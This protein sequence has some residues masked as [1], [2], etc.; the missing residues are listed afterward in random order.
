MTLARNALTPFLLVSLAFHL[1]FLVRW[2]ARAP[3]ERVPE[4]IPVTVL[5]A[6]QES[7]P[8]PAPAGTEAPSRPAETA[9]ATPKRATP[10]TEVPRLQPSAPVAAEEHPSRVEVAKARV[11]ETEPAPTRPLPKLKD[12]LPNAY[13]FSAEQLGGREGSIRLDSKD[14][15]Y[16]PY[17]TLIKQAVEVEWSYPPVALQYGLQGALLV[18]FTILGNGQV[19]D[20]RILRSSG[21][22][23]LDKEATRA[24][25]AAAPFPPIPPRVGKSPL[26]IVAT[27]VYSDKRVRY[28]VAP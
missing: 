26:P 28:E 11:I 4:E 10:A 22:T 17:L 5:P 20:V 9:A 3:R 24:L 19:E 1:M 16:V 15:K 12:L 18:E 8:R 27:F 14:P 7:A 6:P 23:V 2:P 25:R 13:N 21:Y